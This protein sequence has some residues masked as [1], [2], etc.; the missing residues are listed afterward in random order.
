VHFISITEFI[1][2]L[3]DNA[4]THLA[5]LPGEPAPDR[6]NAQQ[7]L[8]AILASLKGTQSSDGQA[9][10]VSADQR[11]MLGFRTRKGDRRVEQP[12]N[13]LPTSLIA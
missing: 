13:A 2:A 8:Q 4:Q 9:A 6:L 12:G 3:S 5:Q 1:K 10:N 11:E 7:A